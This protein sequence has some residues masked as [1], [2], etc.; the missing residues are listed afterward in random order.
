ME[1]NNDDD[2]VDCNIDDLAHEL[3]RVRKLKSAQMHLFY[4]A[5]D[6]KKVSR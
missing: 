3:L 1:N 2:D 6:L 4:V 5:L